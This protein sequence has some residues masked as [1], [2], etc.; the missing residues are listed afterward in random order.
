M[1]VRLTYAEFTR[2]RG[3]AVARLDQSQAAGLH[4]AKRYPR[5][6][7]ERL[8]DDVLGACGELAFCKAV[9]IE[10]DA[11]IGNFHGA[12]VLDRVQV[13]ATWRHDGCL[14]HRVDEPVDHWYYLVTGDPPELTVRGGIRGDRARRGEWLRQW[15]G[16]SPVWAVPQGVLM[17]LR[18]RVAPVTPE[19]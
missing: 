6:W 18:P 1:L 5:G 13:R 4:A 9:G 16:G 19:A 14:L 7:T 17:P 12:D 11:R 2:A 15:N 8:R 3:I 10:W